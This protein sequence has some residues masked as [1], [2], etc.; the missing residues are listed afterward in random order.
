LLTVLA[1]TLGLSTAHAYPSYNIALPNGEYIE[2]TEDLKVKAIGGYITAKR[3]WTNSRWYLNPEW[4]DLKFTYDPLDGSV[5]AIDRGGA[6][7]ERSG[8]IWSLE[9]N[10]HIRKDASGYRWGK[11]DGAWATYDSQGRITGTG[12]RNTL[13]AAIEYNGQGQ[14]SQAK[15]AKG[16]LALAFTYNAQGLLETVAD[17]TGRHVTYSYTNNRLTKVTDVMGNDWTYTYD[18]QGQIQTRTDPEGNEI[19]LFYVD[20]N[21]AGD[22]NGT[23]FKATVPSQPNTT[24]VVS[25]ARI[26][27]DVKTAK[28]GSYTDAENNVTVYQYQYNRTSR[29]YTVTRISPEG[30]RTTN[31][32]DRNGRN[33]QSQTGNLTHRSVIRESDTVEAVTDA[34][35][36][37]TRI[38]Y[39]GNR[40]ILRTVY[41]DGSSTSTTYN[42]YNQ[43]LT[44]TD[45]LGTV[46]Q[47]DYDQKGNLTKLTEARGYPEQRITEHQ[48]DS[49]GQRTRTT[50]K[51]D[52][53][54]D[55]IVT[56]W[57]Y[58][59]YGNVTEETNAENHTTKYTYDVMGKIVTI[60]DPR[61]A[62]TEYENNKAGYLVKQTEA[63]GTP[64]QRTLTVA[65]GKN[66]NRTSVTDARGNTAT[67]IYDKENRLIKTVDA[68]SGV[69]E[70]KY[71][72]GGRII[73][74]INADGGTEFWGYDSDGRFT[75]I[76]DTAGN[77]TETVYGTAGSGLEGLVVARQYATYK[78]E[79]RYNVRNLQVQTIQ[80]LDANQKH[81]T[82]TEYDAVGNAVKRA[83]ALNQTSQYS[84][85][86]LSQQT[87]ETDY[88]GSATHY[89]YDR[90]GRLTA[91]TDAKG[92][93]T[94]YEYNKRGQKTKE[95]RPMGETTTYAYDANGNLIEYKSASGRKRIYTYNALNQKTKE[96]HYLPN[97]TTPSRVIA[98]TYNAN[99]L[100]T[101]YDD[102]ENSQKISSAAYEYDAANRRIS[103]TIDY[104][105]FSKT[106]TFAYT[107]TGKLLER[108]DPD[109]VKEQY[110]WND[111]GQLKQITLNG[112]HT[113]ELSDYKWYE[114]QTVVWPNE[115]RQTDNYDALMN[116]QSRQVKKGEE[117]RLDRQYIY[118]A[119]SGIT[120]IAKEGQDTAY[121]YDAA[122]RLTSV[123]V[124][125]GSPVPSESYTYDSVHNRL[126][127]AEGQSYVYNQNHQLTFILKKEDEQTVPV[128]SYTYNEDGHLIQEEDQANKREYVYD[129]NERLI[130]VKDN[131]TTI[132]KYR[133]DPF[134]RRV[135][136]EAGQTTWYGYTDVGLAAEYTETGGQ[137]VSYGYW[138]D[139]GWQTNPLYKR[140]GTNYYYYHNDHLGTPQRLTNQ[141]GETSWAGAYE[142]FGKVKE[143]KTETN[144]PHRFPGQYQDDETNLY[145]NYHRDY[146][147]TLG[148]YI[149]S[150]PVGQDAG[151][152]TYTYTK[153]RPVVFSDAMGLAE[154]C[155][156]CD[157]SN[158]CNSEG[159]KKWWDTGKYGGLVM[160]C[161]GKKVPCNYPPCQNGGGGGAF[162]YI[163]ACIIAHE[164]VH[165]NDSRLEECKGCAS[166]AL[167][168]FGDEGSRR[169]GECSAH[170]AEIECLERN[171]KGEQRCKERVAQLRENARGSYG[172]DL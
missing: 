166:Y 77:V 57:K 49:Y 127:D 139:K 82:Q 47:Y 120:K 97:Q 84:Y 103:Q 137:I 114:P 4:S 148:R 143:T 65:Y 9:K 87:M 29:Q 163:C 46:T 102:R 135:K 43:I 169:S 138:P 172:C 115:I 95:I 141:Q 23:G 63:K 62:I 152:N 22:W 111:K 94:R 80:N 32:Y 113:I 129:A 92:S 155:C 108:T 159:A 11:Q 133:Y 89:Q 76:T 151:I 45:E 19:K 7:Y 158:C 132:A 171:C 79:Y 20:N 142:A 26:I 69:S 18:S 117:P 73:Q 109:N 118:N 44:Q 96:E 54:A 33:L 40:N 56:Q 66:G 112:T 27:R 116:I 37:V 106:H 67:Y 125:E 160:C 170:K 8:D 3:V 104:G 71:S 101:G 91:I 55:D 1:I 88:S 42:P 50:L 149:E 16:N 105:S 81:T 70:V 157:M 68:A 168:G 90:F 162:S 17:R 60:T 100:L 126:T 165:A 38:T 12:D 83:N 10:Y 153:S 124:P 110:A 93:A 41:P 140:E 121:G 48:Y 28:V 119:I 21:P 72:T 51:G 64:E 107:A 61:G 5:K 31:V 35:G 24:G 39:D 131:G 58:D 14:R 2:T 34:R 30:V 161:C 145:Q 59:D 86:A 167:P 75:L 154:E 150:D 146:N 122:G 74:K 123:A 15:D 144:N 6:I 156:D 164:R 52:T 130:E 136:K 147:P 85:D 36:L 128:K 134:G 99:G 13:H 98:Y 25:T 78:E 53:T